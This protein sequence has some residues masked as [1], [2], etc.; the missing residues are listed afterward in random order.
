MYSKQRMRIKSQF[1]VDL[2][3]GS[4]IKI[5]KRGLDE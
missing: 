4:M 2:F 1:I 5:A 3:I